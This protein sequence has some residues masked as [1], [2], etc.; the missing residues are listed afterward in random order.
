MSKVP[1]LPEVETRIAKLSDALHDA[2]IA[3]ITDGVFTTKDH[4]EFT[5]LTR[6]AVEAHF[7][8]LGSLAALMM[9]RI[10][11]GKGTRPEAMELVATVFVSELESML[12]D[13]VDI[14]DEEDAF[15]NDTE[16]NGTTH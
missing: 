5:R 14:L 10:Q 8:V 4:V 2:T 1:T 3:E 12:Q 13:A 11:N 6:I 9:A 15:G 16:G 7:S